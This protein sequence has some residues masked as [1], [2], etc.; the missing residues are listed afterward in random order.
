MAAAFRTAQDK[1]LKLA[2]RLPVQPSIKI[3]SGGCGLFSDVFMS[4]NGIQFCA[5]HGLSGSVHWGRRSLYFDP[6]KRGNA[7]AYFFAGSHFDF[8]RAYVAKGWRL[9]FLPGG[10]NYAGPADESPR[11]GLKRMIDQFAA[12]RD[13]IVREVESFRQTR[14]QAPKV[15]GVHVRRTDV[16]S[17]FESRKAQPAMNFVDEAQNWLGENQNGLV[18]LATDD[19]EVVENFRTHLGDKVAYQNALRS[20]SGVSIH[21]HFDGGIDGSPFLKGREAMIDALILSR[22]DFLIRCFSYLTAYSLC[23]NPDLPFLD[24]DKKNL[25]VMRTPWLHK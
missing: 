1:L 22:C 10:D 2:A 8:S 5:Q 23:I 11:R 20:S 6:Q 14:L 17:N 12:P 21:G 15:L 13:D 19:E 25:G 3:I 9:P 18:F 4:L 7:H 16:V 24:L